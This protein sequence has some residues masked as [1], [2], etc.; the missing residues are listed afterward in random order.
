MSL[1]NELIVYYLRIILQLL[2]SK[3]V[4]KTSGLG[5]GWLGGKVGQHE[6]KTRI[7]RPSDHT[8]T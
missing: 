6:V 7:Y 5:L 3:F 8:E 1:Y 2:F 4:V